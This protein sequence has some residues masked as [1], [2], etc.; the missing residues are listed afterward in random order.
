MSTSFWPGEILLQSLCQFDCNQETPKFLMLRDQKILAP[1]H[2]LSYFSLVRFPFFL[3]V[4]TEVKV[5]NRKGQSFSSKSNLV[6]ESFSFW[7]YLRECS[8]SYVRSVSTAD[9]RCTS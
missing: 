5:E 2:C 1:L 7:I 9:R 4:T 8:T 3:R 6:I